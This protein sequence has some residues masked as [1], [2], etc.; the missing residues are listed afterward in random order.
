MISVIVVFV[1]TTFWGYGSYSSRSGGT[2]TP[3]QD[4]A[5]A[6]I[7][8]RPVMRSQLDQGVLE[9]AER[10]SST[11]DIKDAEVVALRRSVL[12]NIAIA[13]QFQKELDR[14]HIEVSDEE[15]VN[16][17][18]EVEN[19][20]PTKESYQEYLEQSGATEKQ[21]R[22]Q[23]REDLS[24]K[25]LLENATAGVTISGDEDVKT[26]DA[27]KGLI[28]T[29]R[30]SVGVQM[31]L[32]TSQDRADAALARMR[33]GESWDVVLD[34][35]SAD[36]RERTSGD[37]TLS[38]EEGQVPPQIWES[39]ASADNDALVGPVLLESQD[40]YVI[41]KV[42]SDV[43]GVL[44]FDAVS[45]DVREMV[46]G[47]KRRAAQESF[48]QE[49]RARAD[50]KI[51]DEELFTVRPVSG[52]VSGDQSRSL[53]Q[54]P[55]S[56]EVVV[57]PEVTSEVISPEVLAPASTTE[58]TP[59]SPEVSAAATVPQSSEPAIVAPEMRSPEASTAAPE[60]GAAETP[61]VPAVAPETLSSEVPAVVSPEETP[62]SSDVSGN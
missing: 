13:G 6:E 15:V 44:S 23:I 25:K 54:K 7:D 5:V 18:K 32:F 3:G 34:A 4:Y 49:L 17:V 57:S 10:S 11:K 48:L 40:Y 12:D 1:V 60:T 35:F 9:L 58:T 50:V 8:G 24:R 28:F 16:A 42:R 30:P 45:A 27:L 56:A 41:R 46:L 38:F 26:Y 61:E 47:Q 22:A 55:L 31:G 37:E 36:L 62:T 2:R 59:V 21:I 43:G 51:L 19:Q 39:V 53:D 14:S 52:D 33:G 20:F 29:R